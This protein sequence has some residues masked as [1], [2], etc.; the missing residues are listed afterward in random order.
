MGNLLKHHHSDVRVRAFGVLTLS[1][2][3]T[4][5][6][7]RKILQSLVENLAYV[8][9]E[10]DPKTRSDVLIL[11]DKMITRLRA[12]ASMLS[13]AETEHL[14]LKTETD[15]NTGYVHLEKCHDFMVWFVKFLED[16]LVPSASYARH[17]MALKSLCYI[18]ESGLDETR[19]VTSTVHSLD[20]RTRWP[21][22]ILLH[23]SSMKCALLQLLFDAYED[24]RT[25]ASSI[26][27][28][29]LHPV[30]GSWTKP[31]TADRQEI[32]RNLS[33]RISLTPSLQDLAEQTQ[34]DIRYL[35]RRAEIVASYSNRAD[36]A[37]GMARL[38]GLYFRI[39]NKTALPNVPDNS[40]STVES[41]RMDGRDA[42]F[43]GYQVLNSILAPLEVALVSIDND[44]DAALP[45]VAL[46]GRLLGL[47]SGSG[48]SAFTLLSL[49][50][51]C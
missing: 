15:V 46:H 23:H 43:S 42:M 36:H 25:M 9:G 50:D 33:P 17:I 38:Y 20:G 47:R 3:A 51:L 2:S 39:A 11:V 12:S 19:W 34:S 40:A 5:P 24:V 13:K 7:Y 49:T 48:S 16:E 18:L 32:E 10:T 44:I 6:F 21:F 8:Y 41:H 35:L 29:V 22:R 4:S 30:Y 37:D 27:S 31:P 28:A 45:G 1:A 26:L 14:K